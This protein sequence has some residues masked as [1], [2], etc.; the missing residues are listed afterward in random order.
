MRM[1]IKFTV[2]VES[3][4]TAIRDGK[5]AKVFPQIMEDLNP[6]AAY[7]FPEGGERGGFLIVDMQESAQVAEIA[8]R[9]FF[10]LNARIEMT[11]VMDV[12][13]LQKALSGVPETI[14]RYG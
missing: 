1:M 4:N 14:R 10:G 13:D 3:G 5:F 11:P 2:P 12:D 9:F 7:F 6:E 8:E